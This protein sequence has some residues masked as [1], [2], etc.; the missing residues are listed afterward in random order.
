M[1]SK[2][3]HLSR[4]TRRKISEARLKRKKR[5][6][7]INSPETRKKI[8]K[9]LMG[10]IMSEEQKRKMSEINK[11]KKLS[12]EHKGKLSK[13]L[14][15]NVP[16]NK[17]KTGVY[18]EANLKRMSEALKG[19]K[20]P[21]WQGGKSFEPYTV[22]WTATLKR[23]IRER[24]HYICQLCG[25]PQGDRALDVHHIDYHKK[26]CN[27]DNLIS[28]CHSCHLKTNYNRKDWTNYFQNRL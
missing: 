10:H 11:G 20:N 9:T 7:Y 28:L 1:I 2:K 6:G 4:E 22:D 13:A 5:L 23:S 8:S 15:G 18:S 24:D 3:K 16:W 25:K 19:N 26:N 14:K 21:L 12:E 27:P 17:G